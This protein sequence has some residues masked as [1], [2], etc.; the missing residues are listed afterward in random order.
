MADEPIRRDFRAEVTQNLVDML[1]KGTAPWQKPW[2][3]E[4]ASL[5]M[6]FNPTTDQP[7]RGGNALHLLAMGMAKGNEDPRWMTYRQA[8]EQ[9][10]QVRKGGKGTSIEFWQFPARGDGKEAK[11]GQGTKAENDGKRST[12]PLHRTYTVFNASQIEGVLV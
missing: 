5:N 9:G 8:N 6:P 3:P 1:E 12:A 7:Y 10:W 11:E 4:K 2:D